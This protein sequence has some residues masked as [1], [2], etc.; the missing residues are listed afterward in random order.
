MDFQ[1]KPILLEKNHVGVIFC[2]SKNRLIGSGKMLDKMSKKAISTVIGSDL[3]F[4]KRKSK[5]F[6]YAIV[7]SS[8]NLK[9]SKLYVFKLSDLSKFSARD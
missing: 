9:L 5:L 4:Q 7:H 8:N 2:D 3:S 6:D 1:F